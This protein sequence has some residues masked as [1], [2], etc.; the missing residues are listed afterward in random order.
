ML[1]DSSD[2]YYTKDELRE[3][4]SYDLWIA[5]NEIFARHGRGFS[6]P[7][8]QEYFNNKTWYT[9]LY[10]PEEWDTTQSISGIESQNAALMLEVEE[11]R[12]SAYL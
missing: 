10:S 12:N 2:R 1:A 6:D 3:Y 7:D 9:R 5:R 4:S 8:L 11:E